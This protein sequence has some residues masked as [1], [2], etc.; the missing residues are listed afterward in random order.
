MSS[1]VPTCSQLGVTRAHLGLTWVPPLCWDGPVCT[2][3][4][5]GESEERSLKAEEPERPCGRGFGGP[6]RSAS[7]GSRMAPSSGG[8]GPLL[9]GVAVGR[10]TFR[11]IASRVLGLLGPWAATSPSAKGCLACQTLAATV[12]GTLS[13]QML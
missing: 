9:A 4:F 11:V 13:Q 2:P 1:P 6:G 5:G 12:W 7:W 8:H 3:V 10:P